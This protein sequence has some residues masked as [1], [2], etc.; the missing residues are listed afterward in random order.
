MLLYKLKEHVYI[1]NPGIIRFPLLELE[2]PIEAP[3]IG[4]IL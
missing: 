4:D 2:S 1:G 3:H